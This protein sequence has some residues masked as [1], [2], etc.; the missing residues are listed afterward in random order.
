MTLA[1]KKI[2]GNE[3]LDSKAVELMVVAGAQEKAGNY[4]KNCLLDKGSSTSMKSCLVGEVKKAVMN[5]VGLDSTTEFMSESDIYGFVAKGSKMEG[6][7]FVS[8]CIKTAGD[9]S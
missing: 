2:P 4:M 3:Q 7:D 8:S 9:V 6:V 5:A 1:L